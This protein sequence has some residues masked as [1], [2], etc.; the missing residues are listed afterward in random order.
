MDKKVDIF[1]AKIFIFASKTHDDLEYFCK[2]RTID[3]MVIL[4]PIL[5]GFECKVLSF[6]FDIVTNSWTEVSLFRW[7]DSY[8]DITSFSI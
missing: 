2:A 4:A 3:H 5:L 6:V 7:T 1:G 8:S